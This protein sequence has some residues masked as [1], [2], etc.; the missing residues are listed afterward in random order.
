MLDWWDSIYHI[1]YF[2]LQKFN[3]GVGIWIV[4]LLSLN[5]EKKPIGFIKI[6]SDCEMS[7]YWSV[8]L[9][10]LTVL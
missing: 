4:R 1:L 8:G 10:D 6:L 7:N 5:T 3:V 9:W 2:L